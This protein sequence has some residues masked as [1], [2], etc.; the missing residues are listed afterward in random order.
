[1]NNQ[2]TYNKC[3]EGLAKQNFE[4]AVVERALGKACTY[5]DAEGRRCAAGQ[6]LSAGDIVLLREENLMTTRWRALPTSVTRGY[7]H[8]LVH[9]L[10]RAHDQVIESRGNPDMRANLR[11]VGEAF[12][13]EIPEVL[14]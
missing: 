12:G 9:A 7:D 2:E 14:K 1:M 4:P 3:V 5:Q 10:Q 11:A 13:L 8:R 6:L